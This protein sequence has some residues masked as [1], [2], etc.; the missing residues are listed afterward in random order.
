MNNDTSNDTTI[1]TLQKQVKEKK[2]L[3]KKS[4]KWQP[5]TNCSIIF[6]D[7]QHNIQVLS[8][9]SLQYMLIVLNSYK[10]SAK[11]LNLLDSFSISGYNIEDWIKD[12]TNRLQHLNIRE[13]EK[14]L[15]AMESKLDSLL[16]NSKRV[17][18][19]LQDIAEL[20]K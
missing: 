3:I 10:M 13:E 18:I 11:E 15:T 4:S 1:L 17:E 16:S 12:I 20:L 2:A 14:K 7:H 19:E 6:N 8:K 9:E 5:I